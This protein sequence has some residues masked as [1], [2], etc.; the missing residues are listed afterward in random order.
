[1]IGVSIISI[2]A[3]V[4]MMASAVSPIH[5]KL[6]PDGAPSVNGL[7]NTPESITEK[8]YFTNVS[9]PE[10]L[11]YMPDKAKSTGQ[12][13][14]V[15]PGGSYRNVCTPREGDKTAQWLTDNGITAIVLKYR[16][17]NG[18]YDIPLEDG[19]AAMHMIRDKAGEWGYSRENVG[20]IGF[21]AGGHFVSN[22]ITR[23]PDADA[24]PEFAVLVYP[25][26]SMNYSNAK[27]R[28]NLLGDKSDDQQMRKAFSTNENVH[29]DVPETM[30]VLSDNDRLVK[31]ENS[32][33]FY[34]SLKQ[35]G[36]KSEMH[37]FP[38]GGHGFWM[39]DNFEHAAEAYPMVMR[40]IKQH[41]LSTKTK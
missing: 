33:R 27:T 20:A 30:I 32:L 7:E 37:I 26:I 23:Y 18:H 13:M 22:L 21:S 40:W 41:D 38:T 11:V 17:P 39:R 19:A 3:G 6:Y 14:L 35:N 10:L 16:M 2:F 15:V 8:G 25:V 28:E 36:I 24:R 5:V 1:M 29:K 12:A 34:R 31:P 4:A 9:D